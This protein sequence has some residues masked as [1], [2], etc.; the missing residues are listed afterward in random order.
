MCAQI[1]AEGSYGHEPVAITRGLDAMGEGLWLDLVTANAG[2]EAQVSAAEARRTI[3]VCLAA[4]FPK[5][6]R[7]GAIMSFTLPP[8][9]AAWRD[10]ARAF[11]D[12]ANCSRSSSKRR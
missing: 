4:L 10:K 2:I 8:E 6:F 5:H 7:D 12:Q 1:I 9:A 11:V 3:R